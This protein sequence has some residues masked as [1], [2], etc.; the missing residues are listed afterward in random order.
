MAESLI[1]RINIEGLLNKYVQVAERAFRSRVEEANLNL[2]GELLS[3][4]RTEAAVAAQGFVEA[5]LKMAG[6]ARFK[7]LRRMD[8]FRSP[9]V[10][11]LEYFVEKVGV[12]QFAFVPGYGNG[13]RPATEIQSIER[14]AWAL[15]M[16]RHR[17]PSVKRGYRG[18]YS[19]PLLKDVLP[20]LFFDLKQQAGLT[21]LRQLKLTFTND[22]AG[23]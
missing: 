5:R 22:G 12:E 8:Y 2:S 15:K 20:N 21:A 11:V 7:D 9:P 1:D 6:Y 10:S 19:D 17:Y 16:V 23:S 4:F 13:T 3:S 14:I 18:I